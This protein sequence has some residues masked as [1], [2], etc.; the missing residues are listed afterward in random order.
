MIVS[1]S[2]SILDPAFRRSVREP[3]SRNARLPFFRDEG[4]G[5]GERLLLFGAGCCGFRGDEQ[6]RS[7]ARHRIEPLLR[8]LPRN[9]GRDGDAIGVHREEA[10]VLRQAKGQRIHAHAPGA[11]PKLAAGIVAGALHVEDARSQMADCIA[12]KNEHFF[13]GRGSNGLV[14]FSDNLGVR[15]G[16]VMK[17]PTRKRR[18]RP[19]LKTP[20]P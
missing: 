17:R 16:S 12:A 19:H 18:P 1:L 8:Q 7:A 15:L 4:E 13:S 3:V 11:F 14:E 10:S 6:R 9:G 5:L 2:T 20:L